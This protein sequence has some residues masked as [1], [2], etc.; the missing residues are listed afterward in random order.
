MEGERPSRSRWKSPWLWIGLSCGVLI[1]GFVVIVLLNLAVFLGYRQM[2]GRIREEPVLLAAEVMARRDPDVTVVS[3]DEENH[4]VTLRNQKTGERFVLGQTEQNQLRIQT[5]VGE[6]IPQAGGV[7]LSRNPEEKLLLG[8]AAGP[9][10]SWVPAPAYPGL[11]LRPVYALAAGGVDSGCAVVIPAGPVQEFYRRYQD[12]LARRGFQVLPAGESLSASAPDLRSSLFL[13][14]SPQG[15][16]P[17]VLLNW[18]R[19]AGNHQAK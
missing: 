19:L 6:V 10:P 5:D 9:P 14:P 11:K 17:G 18:S 2:R 3:R 1:L 8:S 4:T 13:S 15:G 7:W 16:P 12:E